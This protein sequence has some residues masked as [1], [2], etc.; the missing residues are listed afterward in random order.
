MKKDQLEQFISDNRAEFDEAIPS[1]GV[2]ANIDKALETGKPVQKKRFWK[3]SRI[4]V[5]AS[6]LIIAG[7][8]LGYVMAT[9]DA[10]PI[11]HTEISKDYQDMSAYYERQLQDKTAKLVSYQHQD[12]SI[13]RDLEQFD[14]V[15][16]ELKEELQNVP[17]GTEEKVIHAMI[18]S[19]QAKIMLLDR[20]LEQL[21]H[22]NHPKNNDNGSV[23]L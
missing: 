23:K 13:D 11:A 15:L 18:Q 5:A 19:Y 14:Q 3:L 6:F 4:A 7:I 16:E 1:L 9:P 21:N 2:W 12:S 8:A 17:K 22:V 20:V 10:H